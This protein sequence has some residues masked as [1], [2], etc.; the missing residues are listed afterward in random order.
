[1]GRFCHGCA[2][3]EGPARSDQDSACRWPH[4]RSEKVTGVTRPCAMSPVS[5]NLVGP[6]ESVSPEY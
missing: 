4:V 5:W 2:Y 1:M 6:I 3:E